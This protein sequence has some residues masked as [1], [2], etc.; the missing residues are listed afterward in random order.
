MDIGQLY[1]EY[2]SA[3]YRFALRL[4]HESA[5]AEDLVQ[6]TM[7]QAM[8]NM[9][10]LNQL[11]RH[12]RRAWLHRTLKN[13][14]IDQTRRLHRHDELMALLDAE[15]DTVAD[16]QP[17]I[18]M[19]PDPFEVVPEQYKELIQMRYVLDMSSTEISE[20][21]GI[22][23]ATVRSRLHLAMKEMRRNKHKLS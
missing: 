6:D 11:K 21:L 12:Q 16:F 14:F 19:E 22:P 7:V 13:R 5:W 20:Q 8:G 1:E 15:T 17:E 4:T 3:L 23:P 18:S 9:L 2:E 10:L